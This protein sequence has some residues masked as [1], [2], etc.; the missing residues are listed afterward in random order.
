[1]A[2][3]AAA[4]TAAHS[5]AL[6]SV[7][8]QAWLPTGR[9]PLHLA[10]PPLAR[11]RPRPCR[12]STLPSMHCVQPWVPPAGC[13]ASPG[14]GCSRCQWRATCPRAARPARPPSPARCATRCPSMRPSR[15]E[16]FASCQLSQLP[17]NYSQRCFLPAGTAVPP[18][19]LCWA[20]AAAARRGSPQLVCSSGPSAKCCLERWP[21]A[22]AHPTTAALRRRT[23]GTGRATMAGPC[24]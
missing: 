3:C 6:G 18:R 16:H 1:M 12:P 14:A 8:Q 2:A 19:T 13:R 17:A 4:W 7:P 11:S 15:C 10:Q 9:Q 5:G 22:P 24:F 21:L 23:T 20:A